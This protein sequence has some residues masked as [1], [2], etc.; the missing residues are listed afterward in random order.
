MA[1]YRRLEGGR[2]GIWKPK[3]PGASIEGV[4]EGR[5]MGE[6]G[7]LL[8]FQGRSGVPWKVPMTARLEDVA[9]QLQEGVTYKL[10]FNGRIALAGGK[11]VK[12]IV[13]DELVDEDDEAPASA[14]TVDESPF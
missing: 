12:D 6:Y 11:T 5:E 9:G 8:L 3:D 1:T 4:F 14:A 2:N 13:V 10:T 7:Q